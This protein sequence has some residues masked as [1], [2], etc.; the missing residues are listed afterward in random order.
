MVRVGA[1]G[2]DGQ[3]A[4]GAAGGVDL[5]VGIEHQFALEIGGK[6]AEHL[7]TV[8]DELVARCV[9][10]G[11]AATQKILVAQAEPVEAADH[12]V[13]GESAPVVAIDLNV[14]SAKFGKPSGADGAVDDADVGRVLGVKNHFP[15]G[16]QVRIDSD[17]GAT[18]V[19]DQTTAGQ[20]QGEGAGNVAGGAQRIRAGSPGQCHRR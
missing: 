3:Q 9:G 14:A 20:A 7:A 18:T 17:E 16:G 1:I 13:T 2:I 6:R 8:E 5:G 4:E 12:R 11:Q 19:D 10:V 15:G